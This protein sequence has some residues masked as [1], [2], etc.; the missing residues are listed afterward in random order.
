MFFLLFKILLA[1]NVNAFADETCVT[2]KCHASIAS[3]A[4]VHP[5]VS[6]GCSTCH[7]AISQQHPQKNVKTFKL[8]QEPPALCATCH[9]PFGTK[10]FVHTAVK[11]GMCTSCHDPHSSPQPKLLLKPANEICLMCHADKTNF[12]YVHG[13]TAAGDCL[14]CHSPHESDNQAQTLKPGV[15]LCTICHSDIQSELKR[16]V[17]HP[18]MEG[19]CN[20][21]HNP[22]GSQ[23]KRFF[24]AEG[25][26]LCFQCH[27]QIEEKLKASTDVHPPIKSE[28]GC[29]SCHLPHA[30]DAPK[31]L[32]KAGKEL[33]LM[34]HAEIIKKEYTVLHGPIKDGQCTPCHDPHGSGNGK[35]LIKEFPTEDTYVPYTENEFELCFS[36]HNRDLVRY[37][38]TSFATGFR[39]GE[40]NLHYLHVNRK[41]KGRNCALCHNIH[42]GALPKLIANDV[43][44]GKWK[45]PIKFTKT[46]T[47]GSCAPGCHRP[48]NYDRKKPGKAP[49]PVKSDD[50]GK[51]Q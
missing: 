22:H 39:D 16:P 19:G 37:P 28:R 49:E 40:R 46:E 48:V 9:A 35:L 42:G 8:T 44:F 51:K 5:A 27:P 7:E 14:M 20:S 36:C 45:L 13:P 24:A 38:E 41:D 30:S 34:C 1:S 2:G 50:K 3:A 11:N 26:N 43:S 6:M 15:E 33:C 29:P 21:C 18:A 10:K 31:L 25:N 4:V 17:V 32:P 12:K 23:F 47:G